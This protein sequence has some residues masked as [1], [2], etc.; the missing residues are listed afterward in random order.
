MT[1][2]TAYG[3]R[4]R[5]SFATGDVSRT[6]QSFKAECDINT[7]MRR[8]QKSGIVSHFAKVQGRYGDFLSAVDYQTALNGVISAQEAFDTLP[9][10]VRKRFGGDP[11]EFLAFAQ[12]A[13][14]RD[15]LIAM[16]LVKAPPK[17]DPVLVEEPVAAPRGAA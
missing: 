5:V 9:A 13:A 2:R 14:N 4:D 6:K 10:A 12:D 16:G 3:P 8:Y 1:F 7:I 15:E 17:P 11:A